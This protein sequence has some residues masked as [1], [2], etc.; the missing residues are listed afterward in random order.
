MC[1]LKIGIIYLM[2]FTIADTA[3]AALINFS[4]TWNGLEPI[5]GTARLTRDGSSSVASTQKAFPGTHPNYPT[6]FIT[7]GLSVVPNTVITITP[8]AQTSFSFLSI[9]DTLFN[10]A[11]LAANYLGDQGSSRVSAVFSI[12]AP[13]SGIVT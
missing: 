6:Y 10:P 9:Y 7:L 4:H 12:T 5:T 3:S 1:K 2:L 8:T 11:S 13:A